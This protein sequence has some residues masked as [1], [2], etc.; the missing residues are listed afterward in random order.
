MVNAESFNLRKLRYPSLD[1]E[2][3]ALCIDIAVS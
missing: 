3:G 1:I 2:I